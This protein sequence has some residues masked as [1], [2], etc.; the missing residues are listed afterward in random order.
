MRGSFRFLHGSLL[1]NRSIFPAPFEV[2]II[3]ERDDYVAEIDLQ[4]AAALLGLDPE[5]RRQVTHI[6]DV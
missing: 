3:K 5:G 6:H 1:D 4:D 2:T